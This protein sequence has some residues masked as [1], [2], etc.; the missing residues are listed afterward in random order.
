MDNL[1]N[2]RGSEKFDEES[3]GLVNPDIEVFTYNNNL[4]GE[5]SKVEAVSRKKTPKVLYNILTKSGRNIT[6]T[7]DHSAVVLKNSEI[8]TVK[9]SELST[10][11]FIPIPRGMASSNKSAESIDVASTLGELKHKY[12]IRSGRIGT[13]KYIGKTS[14]PT[15]ILFTD[16]FFQ[17]VGLFIAEGT[18]L[19]TVSVITNEN[20]DVINLVSSYYKSLGMNCFHNKKQNK[21]KDTRIT[22]Q[23]FCDLLIK[24]G[25][26]GKAGY[27]SVPDVV[28]SASNKHVSKFLQGYY[29]GDGGVEK[30]EI[31]ATTKSKGLASDLAYLLLRFGIVARINTKSKAATNTIVK[32]K[33]AYYRISISGQDNVR[34][35][36]NQIGFITKEKNQK[37]LKLLKSENTNIDTI[38]ELQ[39]IF[40]EIYS[41]LYNSENPAP[42][43]FSEIKL[44]IFKPSRKNLLEILSKIRNR[45]YE[46]QSLEGDGISK[47]QSLPTVQQITDKGTNKKIN[48]LLWEKLGHSWQTMRAGI[49][50]YTKNAL[51]AAGITHGYEIEID[52]VGRALYRCFK[53]TGRSLQKF[54]SSLWSSVLYNK[55]NSRY[56]KLI[57]ARDYIGDVFSKKLEK[58]KRISEKVDWLETLAK[59][60]LFW[61]PIVKVTK[62]KAKHPYVYDLQVKNS[63]FLAGHGGM[64]I[65]NSYFVKLE[66]LRCLNDWNRSNNN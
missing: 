20:A 28:F 3:E 48:S 45:I 8:T 39:S 55:S 12:V 63:V 13:K 46:I 61:D 32:T 50:P 56:E 34:K 49:Q 40:K 52:E 33:R 42:R 57:K 47:L 1:I 23:V 4:K 26:S 62:V 51:M 64:F 2:Q 65:H 37:S 10:E 16:K 30:H 9:G 36:I 18:V 29:E 43:K 15:E 58:L 5:W 19:P 21:F 60:D 59:S 25:I 27:K 54:D 31:T 35:F 22:T 11:Q 53:F 41:E 14:L 7:G 17:V 38:P 6:I 44:G 66:A 24:L